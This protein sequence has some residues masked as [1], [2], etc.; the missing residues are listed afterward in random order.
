MN[1]QIFFFFLNS[2]FAIVILKKIHTYR[3]LFTRNIKY[4]VHFWLPVFLSYNV[5]SAQNVVS[6]NLVSIRDLHVRPHL[7]RLLNG[8]HPPA[9]KPGF[10]PVFTQIGINF[11]M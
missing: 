10:E 6:D 5:Q 1:N 9:K 8:L 7:I 11:M 2:D 3:S 4:D